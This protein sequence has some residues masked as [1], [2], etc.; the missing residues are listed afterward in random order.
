M[1]YQ[2]LVSRTH[3]TVGGN[4]TFTEIKFKIQE[5]INTFKIGT[6]NYILDKKLLFLSSHPKFSNPLY[7]PR[8]PASNASESGGFRTLRT[9]L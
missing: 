8:S 7:K 9:A 1:S 4:H 6:L 2:S 3:K 5:S